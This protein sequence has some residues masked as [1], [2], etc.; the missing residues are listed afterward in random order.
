MLHRDPMHLYLSWDIVLHVQVTQ[1]LHL[2]RVARHEI[3]SWIDV[4]HVLCL[5]M[6]PTLQ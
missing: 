4:N 6:G 1:M 3:A 2:T 5:H